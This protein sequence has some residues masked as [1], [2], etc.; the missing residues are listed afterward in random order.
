MFLLSFPVA[1]V[2]L[3][4]AKKPIATWQY[5]DFFGSDESVFLGAGD[6]LMGTDISARVYGNPILAPVV[7]VVNQAPN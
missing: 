2:A 1:D 7:E 5:F 3:T 4:D 6:S